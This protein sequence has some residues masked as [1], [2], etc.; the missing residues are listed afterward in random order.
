MGRKNSKKLTR[1]KGGKKQRHKSY[2][3]QMLKGVLEITRSGMGFVIVPDLE[4]DILIRPGDFNTALHGDT[5]RISIKSGHG[6]RQQGV[7]ESVLQRKR[8]EF[9]GHIEMNKGFAFF[10]A[11]MDKPMPDIFIPLENISGA[12]DNDRV[13]VKLLSWEKDGKRPVGKVLSILEAENTNDVAMKE[14]L[15]E[16]GFPLQFSDEALEVA[17][18]IPEIISASEIKKRNDIRS[19]L[20]F[21]IDPVDAKDFD[22]AISFRKLK[23]GNYEIGV[24]I[25]DV[26]HY[27]EADN[28]L[29]K[30]AYQRA[31]SVYLP[32]RV[33]PM[34]PEHISNVLCSLRPNEDK[35]TFSSIFQITPKGEIKQYWLGKT[36]IHSDHRF[37][38][39]EVQAIIEEKAGQYAEEILILNDLAQKMR[40]KRFRHGAISFSSQE[41]RFKLDEKGDPIGIM[42]KESKESHQLIEEFMLLANRTV[43]ENL[44]KIKVNNKALPFPYRV[45]DDPDEE[46]LL[47]FAAFAKKFGHTFDTSSPDTIAASFNQL[48]QD[49][50]GRPEQHVLEQL[51]IRTMAKAKYTIENV[52]HYGLGFEHYCHFTSPIRRYPDVQVHR[53]LEQVLTNK[54]NPDKKLEE[55]C[56]HT[57]ERE[58]AAMEAERAANKYKQVQYMK[59][60]LGE[61]F[62]GVISGVAS[63]GFW[64]ETVEHKCEGLVSVNSLLEYDEF[65]H[66]ES[67]YSLIGQRSGKKFRMGDKV[68]IKV[69][70]ANL[71]KRQLDYEWVV[72]GEAGIEKSSK[73]KSKKKK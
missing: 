33:N 68:W 29:D 28:S 67:D 66:V 43:A 53:I 37:T 35:L 56:K 46:K 5:V 63:F 65:R 14:I 61:E 42:I 4:T 27:V 73:E 41:V 18:R 21:T 57:S 72:A 12:Q 6:R 25:A 2:A 19:I 58:R 44:S 24:H 47:P 20:T 1:H 3:P 62:E 54:I 69:V 9:I 55:K 30:E 59:N 15:L 34:L 36:I 45:H 22:D 50:H 39:E 51:G 64:V 17:A 31:T 16:A 11:E 32:D 8:T 40:K 38:Y 23:N 26:S 52:G 48:L 10:V 60:F 49:V 71:T 70:A 13:M 7:V